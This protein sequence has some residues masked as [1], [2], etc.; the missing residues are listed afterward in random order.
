MK[1]FKRLTAITVSCF[2]FCNASMLIASATEIQNED[3]NAAAI[4]YPNEKVCEAYHALGFSEDDIQRLAYTSTPVREIYP[5]IKASNV[6]TPKTYSV[7]LSCEYDSD[8]YS[9]SSF[10][11]GDFNSIIA[12]QS[13][14]SGS[15]TN[16]STLNMIISAH[17]TISSGTVAL[18][19]LVPKNTDFGYAFAVQA[20]YSGLSIGPMNVQK[21]K[22]P[23]LN[24][25]LIDPNV[26][27]STGIIVPGDV[28]LD[29][30]INNTDSNLLSNYIAESGTL[31]T[32]G[33]I[34]ADIN[35]DGYINASDLSIL[36]QYIGG[37]I[38][39]FYT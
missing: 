31:T 21:F 18:L 14:V 1:F 39:Y 2:L 7:T 10:V 35:R 20:A 15:P 24:S 12:S 25:P 3:Y 9:F 29:G 16:E 22:Q 11:I 17:N 30:Y 19:R 27:F 26:S 32:Y 4:E 36:L 38:S 23:G 33:L 28:N 37:T 34:S 8:Y 13:D 5:Y 6:E